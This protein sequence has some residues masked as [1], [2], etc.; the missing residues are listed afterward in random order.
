MNENKT[1][2]SKDS[3]IEE[4]ITRFPDTVEVFVRFGMPCFVCGEPAWGTVAEL[5]KRYNIEDPE[6]VLQALNEAAQNRSQ[7]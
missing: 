3:S 4:V 2:I 5:M 6:K 7:D 1:L